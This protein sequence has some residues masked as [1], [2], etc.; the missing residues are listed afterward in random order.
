M[1][2]DYM[3]PAG[4]GDEPRPTNMDILQG[5]WRNYEAACRSFPEKAGNDSD[6]Q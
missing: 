2:R 1:L 6:E 4:E 3:K 5:W